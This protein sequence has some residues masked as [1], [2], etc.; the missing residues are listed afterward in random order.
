MDFNRVV[1][2]STPAFRLPQ[3]DLPYQ[4]VYVC[5]YVCYSLYLSWKEHVEYI[6]KKIFS[7]LGMLR[8]ARKVLPRFSCITLYCAMVL[9]SFDYCSIVWDSCGLGNKAYLDKLHRRA[10]SVISGLLLFLLRHVELHAC[11]CAEERH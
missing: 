1:G 5:M 2:R 10:A 6:G 7:R 11:A 8:K 3:T 4:K 9:P